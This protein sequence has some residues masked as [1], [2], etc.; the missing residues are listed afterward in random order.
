MLFHNPSFLPPVRKS[1][2]ERAATKTRLNQFRVKVLRAR[3]PRVPALCPA[4]IA[5]YHGALTWTRAPLAAGSTPA[6]ACAPCAD[7]IA[8]DTPMRSPTTIINRISSNYAEQPEYENNHHNASQR[9]GKVH[10][11]SSGLAGRNLWFGLA[12]RG[13]RRVE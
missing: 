9:N 10:I 8:S 4:F 13:Q 5:M 3:V 12:E 7:W 1:Y 6:L 2:F 11:D